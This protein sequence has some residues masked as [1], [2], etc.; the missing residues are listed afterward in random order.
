[1]NILKGETVELYNIRNYFTDKFLNFFKEHDFHIVEY[2]T[3]PY[4]EDWLYYSQF[5]FKKS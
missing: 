2:Y 5:L 3:K 1:M 4:K